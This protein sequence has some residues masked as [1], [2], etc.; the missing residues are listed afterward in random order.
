MRQLGRGDPTDI[1]ILQVLADRPDQPRPGDALA[2][3]L[4]LPAARMPVRLASL[5]S[6]GYVDSLLLGPDQVSGYVL[7]ERGAAEVVR[8]ASGPAAR[9]EAYA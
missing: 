7:T 2:A 1:E 5:V 3:Q 6:L 4:G 9:P 8:R